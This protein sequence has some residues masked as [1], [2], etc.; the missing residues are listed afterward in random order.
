MVPQGLRLIS[1]R[2]YPPLTF[3]YVSDFG[4]RKLQN[5]FWLGG[6]YAHLNRCVKARN[7]THQGPVKVPALPHGRAIEQAAAQVSSPR[8]SKGCASTQLSYGTLTGPCC[9]T[10]RTPLPNDR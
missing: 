1:V 7:Q 3:N 9:Q 5:L 6:C 8:V 10:H 2:D 4:K